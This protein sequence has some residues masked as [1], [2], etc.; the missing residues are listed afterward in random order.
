MQTVTQVL[1]QILGTPGAPQTRPTAP[2]SPSEWLSSERGRAWREKW[3]KL[4]THHSPVMEKAAIEVADFCFGIW[5]RPGRGRLLL[6]CGMNGTGKTHLAKA[7]FRWCRKVGISQMTVPE[8]NV[9][10][11]ISVEYRHWPTLLDSMRAGEWDAC[12]EFFK[13][14]VVILDDIGSAHDPSRFGM[15]RL[16]QVLTH[17]EWKW[18]VVTTNI[19]PGSWPEHFDQ[20]I[21][22]RFFRNSRIVDLT[23]VPDYATVRP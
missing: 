20:R 2:P 21:A 18:T 19:V 3:L 12:T 7:I 14:D 8:E 16:C 11:P 22:S 23:G 5:H 15:D 13:E 10:R 17:R 9:V 1:H 4:D 6:L